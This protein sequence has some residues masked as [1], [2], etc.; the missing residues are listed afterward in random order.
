MGARTE[1]DEVLSAATFVAG[2]A[3]MPVSLLV[4]AQWIDTRTIQPV[5]IVL[6]SIGLAAAEAE[7]GWLPLMM[8]TAHVRTLALFVGAL[9]VLANLDLFRNTRRPEDEHEGREH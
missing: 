9:C 1:S 3:L 6:H 4:P 8:R 2:L 5:R 7:P